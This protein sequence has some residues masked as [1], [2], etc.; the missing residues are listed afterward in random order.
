MKNTYRTL[1][2]AVVVTTFWSIQMIIFTFFNLKI[3]EK[4][5]TNGLWK[6]YMA[7]KTSDLNQIR[8]FDSI[9]E[10]KSRDMRNPIVVVYKVFI[11]PSLLMMI[12]CTG[13]IVCNNKL[14]HK[15]MQSLT[16]NVF[17]FMSAEISWCTSVLWY[18]STWKID[19][20]YH[21]FGKSWQTRKHKTTEDWR[22]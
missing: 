21:M 11:R 13:K 20:Y 5:N 14:W 10:R 3:L 7:H 2:N 18:L 12:N 4:A 19:T 6:G 8:K 22:S 1:T 9:V 16:F 17:F 15:N